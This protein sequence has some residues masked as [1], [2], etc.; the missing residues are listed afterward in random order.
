M[1]VIAEASADARKATA[2]ATSSTPTRRPRQ[3]TATSPSTLRWPRVVVWQLY[4]AAYFA[5]V[6]IRGTVNHWYPYPFLD[7][8]TLGYLRVLINACAVLLVFVAVA[9]LLVALGR[10]QVRRSSKAAVLPTT[11]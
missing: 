8:G 3:E 1:P 6:L 4:P 10:W 2:R 9:M 5:Y 7:V 11:P